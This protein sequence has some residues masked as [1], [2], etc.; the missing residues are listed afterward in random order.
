MHRHLGDLQHVVAAEGVPGIHDAIVAQGD[1]DP[2]R[3]HLLHAG[4]AP[5]FRIGI[6]AAL[7]HDVDQRVGDRRDL[8]LAHERQ[9]LADVVVVHR[10]H[11]GQV[12]ARHP[13]LE[14]EADGLAGEALD[15]SGIRIVGLVAVHVDEEAALGGDLAE[16][17]HR[18]GA[19]RHR[20]FEM[21]DAADDVHPAVEGA[22][23][24]LR[25]AGRPV[26]AVLG[27]RHE[28]KLH[29]WRHLL[30]ELEERVHRDERIV[31]YVHMASDR[32]AAA[33]DRPHALLPGAVLDVVDREGRRELAPDLD[34]LQQ[35]PAPVGPRAPGAERRVEMEMRI[36]EGRRHQPVVERHHLARLCLDPGRDLP[37]APVPDR[38]VDAD[39][40][41][42]EVGVADEQVE[43]GGLRWVHMRSPRRKGARSAAG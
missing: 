21:R 1:G 39:A 43:H 36:D 23:D 37:D 10:V 35:G 40:A 28:L 8:G 3:D 24:V 14:T 7:D 30:P 12:R 15:V 18:G 2:G 32:Q 5:A 26:V 27:E 6:V 31:G 20:P 38:D 19:V 17:A 13:S 16:R 9:E 22:R 25:R 42:G 4:H 11:R 34:A 41:V 33:R 29:P